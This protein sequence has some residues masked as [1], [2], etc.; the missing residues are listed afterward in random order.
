MGVIVKFEVS[1]DQCWKTIILSTNATFINNYV[2]DIGIALPENWGL[3][4]RNED[5]VFCPDCL[6]EHQRLFP[7]LFKDLE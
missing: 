5:F 6:K 3:H 7:E 1:C 4:P 2:E